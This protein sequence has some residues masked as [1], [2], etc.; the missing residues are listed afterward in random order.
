MGLPHTIR[1]G[2]KGFHAMLARASMLV[3]LAAQGVARAAAM[4]ALLIENGMNPK[5]NPDDHG[6]QH[7]PKDFRGLGIH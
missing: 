7:S 1:S 3:S 5:T 4:G 2:R 6:A